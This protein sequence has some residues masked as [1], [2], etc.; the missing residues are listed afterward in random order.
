MKKMIDSVFTVIILLMGIIHISL[1]SR[2]YPNLN[3]NAVVFMGMGLAFVFL[4]II[5]IVRVLS[6]Q[7]IV[8][9]LCTICNAI[10]IC[11]L[12]LFSLV[13]Q[14]ITPQAL[15]VMGTLS[16]LCVGSVIRLISNSGLK[17]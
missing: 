4:G 8:T 16:A 11:Y 9:L 6:E 14:A 5:N 7:K 15:I 12:I 17:Q 13:I 3:E 10:A 2:F 1:T